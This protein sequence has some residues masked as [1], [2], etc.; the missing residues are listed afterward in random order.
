M[1]AIFR[2][3]VLPAEDESVQAVEMPEGA[4]LVDAQASSS[5]GINLWALVDTDAAETVAK[6][7]LAKTGQQ[8]PEGVDLKPVRTFQ[9]NAG[10]VHLLAIA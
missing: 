6:F 9:T 2:Y 1:R 4:T 5:G 10:A 3:K 8:L 7:Y